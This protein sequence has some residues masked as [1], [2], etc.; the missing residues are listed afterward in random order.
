MPDQTVGWKENL[1]VI[2]KI[3]HTKKMI[4]KDFEVR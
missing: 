4:L 3:K 1:P 2:F